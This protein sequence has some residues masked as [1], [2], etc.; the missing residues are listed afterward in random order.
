LSEYYEVDVDYDGRL[1]TVM[2][3]EGDDGTP[4]AI[5]DTNGDG[6][7]D[8]ALSVDELIECMELDSTIRRISVWTDVQTE[9][10][11]EDYRRG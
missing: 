8:H 7:A 9:L 6:Y 5:A 3:T 2:I 11:P 4:I 10:D 1:D